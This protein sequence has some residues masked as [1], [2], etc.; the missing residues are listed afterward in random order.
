MPYQLLVLFIV[1]CIN[2]E[3]EHRRMLLSAVIIV[4]V[5]AFTQGVGGK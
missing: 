5:S 4:N 2:D 1:V 3:S